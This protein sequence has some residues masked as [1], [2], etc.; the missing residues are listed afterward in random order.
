MKFNFPK[1]I[2]FKDAYKF[3]LLFR[4]GFEYFKDLL[5]DSADT[6]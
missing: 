6:I 3:Q 5:R 2:I 1:D 4:C